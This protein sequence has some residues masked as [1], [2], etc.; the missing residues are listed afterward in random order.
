MSGQIALDP[1]S[2]NLVEGGVA[3]QTVAV[4]ANIGA[5]L[6][7]GGLTFDDVIKTTVFLLTM[8]DFGAMNDVYVTKFA[9]PAPARSTVAVSGLPRGARVEIEAIARRQG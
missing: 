9:A 3:E 5:V 7:A 1:A 8:D 2:G 4:F 6:A